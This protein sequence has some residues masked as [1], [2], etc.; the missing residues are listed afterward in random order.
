MDTAFEESPVPCPRYEG[1]WLTGN[2]KL[3]Y[4]ERVVCVENLNAVQMGVRGVRSIWRKQS[5]VRDIGGIGVGFLSRSDVCNCQANLEVFIAAVMTDA[6]EKKFT[7]ARHQLISSNTFGKQSCFR[8]P[9]L[10]F[11]QYRKKHYSSISETEM[12][13]CD[14]TS[15]GMAIYLTSTSKL[16]QVL[17][18][19]C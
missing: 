7:S 17:P 2:G 6:E 12:R 13:K 5:L 14:L 3:R 16:L 1:C 4:R 18:S 9:L 15:L 19:E 10:L 8:E 11:A